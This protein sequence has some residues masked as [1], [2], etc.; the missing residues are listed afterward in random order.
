V[1]RKVYRHP[2]GRPV[3]QGIDNA[4]ARGHDMLRFLRLAGL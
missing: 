4:F 1:A 3:I 2:V